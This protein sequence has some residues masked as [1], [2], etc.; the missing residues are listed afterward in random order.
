MSR[1]RT[2]LPATLAEL[3]ER[4]V[5]APRTGCLVWDGRMVR[6]GYGQIGISRQHAAELGI[7]QTVLVHRL[8]WELANGPIPEGLQIDHLCRNRACVNV[9]HME[10]VTPSENTQRG[11]GPLLS[12]LRLQDMRSKEREAYQT[13]CK[14]GHALIAD[15]VY[16]DRRGFRNCRE[17]QRARSR[18][19]KLRQK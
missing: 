5:L 17:C 15:N 10:V 11:D 18:V 6:G 8:A 14:H 7:G 3:L 19:W 4:T 16:T 13:H 9:A 1:P 2:P 12:S